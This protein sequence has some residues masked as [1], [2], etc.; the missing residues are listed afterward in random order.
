[1]SLPNGHF[2]QWLHP[3]LLLMFAYGGFETALM[4]A[5]EAKN[6]RRDYPIAL[7]LALVTCT[8][9][10]TATQ[11]IVD[12]VLTNPAATD[13][14]MA[15]A[16]QVI[17]GGWGA[18]LV[19]I[20]V[21]L[22]TYGYLS[23]NILGAPRI[24]FAMAEHGDLPPAMAKVHE[25]FRTPHVAIVLF[26]VLLY[27]FSIIG[28]FE[29]NVF[30]SVISR[31]FY[32]GSVCAALPVLRRKGGV[33]REQFHL[34]MGDFFA[35]LAIGVSLL[36]FPKLDK[37]GLLVMGILAACILANSRWAAC[38]ART[39]GTVANVEKMSERM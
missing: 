30:I 26:A 24:L 7:F 32:Y 3:V 28:K 18:A 4:P 11:V 17:F 9:I 23:A 5:A 15:G 19:S 27:G 20:G 25:R 34:P 12:S 8:V 31:L 36:L 1:M 39:A 13:R 6:P 33:P 35:V 21:L 22:S 14:P 37:G 29:W 38:R 16:A 10:Y 2:A